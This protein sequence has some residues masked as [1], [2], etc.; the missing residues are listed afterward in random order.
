MEKRLDIL[1]MTSTQLAGEATRRLP[2][3]AGVA[4]ALYAKV[5]E[6]GLLEPEALGLSARSAGAWR[7]SFTA[8]LLEPRRVVEEVGEAGT[9]MKVVMATAD[10][11]EIECVLI[12]MPDH[13][14]EG[15]HHTLCVSSQIGC[16]MGCAF[17]E[18]GRMGLIRNLE[19]Q[20]IVSQLLTARIRLGWNFRNVVFMGMGEPLDN[21]DNLVKAL[22]VIVDPRGL[23]LSWER[24][25]VCSSGQVEGIARLKNQGLKRLGLSISLNAGDDATRDRIMPVN[26]KY[27]LTALAEALAAYPSRRNFVLGLNYCL[28]PGIND[29]RE[30]ARLVAAFCGRV[31]R[32]LVNLIPYNPG[33]SPLTR[34][35]TEDETEGFRL[36][37]A[38]EGL[39]VRRRATKGG[40]IMAGCG[41]LGK[42][43]R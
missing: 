19:P 29:S 32:C 2:S 37:L 31:G 13:D 15:I 30:E 25:T 43:G 26:R 41:Q 42:A 33:S 38:E 35:P 1:G 5:F 21:F 6:T 4:G 11:H 23:S 34:A 36:W 12:P 7:A 9:T 18:T 16:R 22:E 24:I 17:C 8:G 28:L 27:N 14:P 20:E 3:G 39:Q 10:G 40:S